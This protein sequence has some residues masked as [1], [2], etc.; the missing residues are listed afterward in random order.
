[1]PRAAHHR[2]R[3]GQAEADNELLV[4]VAELQQAN[5]WRSDC[6]RQELSHH[7]AAPLFHNHLSL[8]A[9]DRRRPG[10]QLNI[11]ISDMRMPLIG[12]SWTPPQGTR[13]RPGVYLPV[14]ERL[15]LAAL[16]G[17]GAVP[18]ADGC[19]IGEGWRQKESRASEACR[20]VGRCRKTGHQL[21]SPPPRRCSS[22]GLTSWC[23]PRRFRCP[24]TSTS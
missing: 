4:A 14:M 22:L 21:G 10:R 1:V 17:D 19:F 16:T 15:R 12:C 24:R 23:H 5:A 7:R 8:P 11:L 6:A 13:L 3:P 18:A 9:P 20:L 2:A